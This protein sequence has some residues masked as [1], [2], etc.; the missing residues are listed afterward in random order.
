MQ[1]ICWMARA[2]NAIPSAAGGRSFSTN[3]P[4]GWTGAA[5]PT[6]TAPT[7]L[8]WL[9]VVNHRPG[10]APLCLQVQPDRTIL[11]DARDSSD[12]DGHRLTAH[13]WFYQAASS[14]Q[15]PLALADADSL[16]CR[17]TMPA[18]ASGKS[19]HLILRVTDS[20]APPLTAF[21]RIILSQ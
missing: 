21:R 15:G 12:P 3:L 7:I 1:Q 18:A 9:A 14:Y 10:T 17:V 19:I 2:M 8:P 20:G 4:P 6:A 16:C 13:W 5:Q 11:L